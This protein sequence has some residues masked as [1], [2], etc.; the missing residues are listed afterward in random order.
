MSKV[1]SPPSKKENRRA[2]MRRLAQ[3]RRVMDNKVA[4]LL[5]HTLPSKKLKPPAPAAPPSEAADA[6]SIGLKKEIFMDQ[7]QSL[8]PSKKKLKAQLFH[9]QSP[10]EQASKQ[11]PAKGTG[12]KQADNAP[13]FKRET[14]RTLSEE[15]HQ[16]CLYV[17]VVH[18][19]SM[20][21][22]KCS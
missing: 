21:C 16:F 12:S 4:K 7:L 9:Y 13:W 11:R 19:T 5:R 2:Q 14:C 22:S 6:T 10:L 20:R 18:N 1:V 17:E 3:E 15:L 8:L